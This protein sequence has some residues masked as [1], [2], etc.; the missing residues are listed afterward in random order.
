MEKVLSQEERI[1]RA[2]EIYLRRAR[3]NNN[4]ATYRQIN[5]DRPKERTFTNKYKFLKRIALQVVISLLLYCVFYL[6]YT[7]DYS[8]SDI[9]I[10]KIDE[11]LAYDID[12]DIMYKYINEHIMLIFSNKNTD[13]TNINEEDI[14]EVNE[15]QSQI[16][17]KEEI[18]STTESIEEGNIETKVEEPVVESI[19]ETNIS[20]E[21]SL[22]NKYSIIVPVTGGYIS[23]RFGARESTSEIVSTN[24]KGIDIAVPTRYKYSFCNVRHSSSFYCV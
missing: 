10:N 5:I 15:E 12:F 18:N 6:V 21:D 4:N 2:E 7:T 3:Y 23:S 9:T 11:I 1:R 19:Q 14:Q 24:H 16:E 13:N 22:Q 20:E 8:F 17:N